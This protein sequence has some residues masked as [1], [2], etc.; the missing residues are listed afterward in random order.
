[1][2]GGARSEVRFS[3]RLMAVQKEQDAAGKIVPHAPAAALALDDVPFGR[4]V[5][6]ALG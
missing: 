1:M 3:V 5:P 2:I 6:K 4:V